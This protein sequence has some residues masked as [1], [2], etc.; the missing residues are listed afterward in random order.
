MYKVGLLVTAF[1]RSCGYTRGGGCTRRVF[2]EVVLLLDAVV[3]VVKVRL[4]LQ[5]RPGE[6]FNT[7][8]LS[9]FEVTHAPQSVCAKDDAPTNMSSM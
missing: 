7:P 2:M 4:V 3:M 5:I 8:A 1:D 9:A 6:P